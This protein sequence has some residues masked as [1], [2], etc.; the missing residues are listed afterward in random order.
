MIEDALVL[1]RA[2]RQLPEPLA[3]RTLRES[4]GLTQA[5]VAAGV[6]ATRAAVTRWEN[7]SREVSDRF[8]VRYLQALE[9]FAFEIAEEGLEVRGSEL[10]ADE[11]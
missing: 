2:R 11:Q 6:G 3:R 4:V 5:D 9:R 1:A 8:V 7:G 10:A